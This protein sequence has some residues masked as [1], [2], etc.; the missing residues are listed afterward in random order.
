[1]STERLLDI[2]GYTFLS[3]AIVLLGFYGSPLENLINGKS[4]YIIYAILG[5]VL[6][7][8]V[9]QF[10]L[11]VFPD[12]SNSDES[13][14]SAISGYLIGIVAVFVFA[15][16]FYNIETAKDNKRLIEAVVIDKTKNI[17]YS[18]TYLRLNIYGKE[19]RFNPSSE[20]W[21]QI[22]IDD[23]LVLNVGQGKL[24]YDYIFEF[25]KK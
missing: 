20:E 18:T 19:E 21:N 6:S 13:R 23:T 4:F 15:S 10:I 11:K 8:A 5:T 17:K 22:E 24:G 12:Y 2:I 14:L 16:A 25:L 3:A 1:M 7:L 9:V